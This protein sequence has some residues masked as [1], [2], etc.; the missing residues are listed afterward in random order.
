MS[1]PNPETV[2]SSDGRSLN[3][4]GETPITTVDIAPARAV[5]M[6]ESVTGGA[7]IVCFWRLKTHLG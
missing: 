3:R 6:H 5:V 7:N 2:Q 4:W 1:T